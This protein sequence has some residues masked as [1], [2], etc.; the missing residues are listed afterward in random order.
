MTRLL[1]GQM[2]EIE[3]GTGEQKRRWHIHRELLIYQSELLEEEIGGKKNGDKIHLPDQ[4][5][6][7]FELFLKWLY[8]GKLDDVSDIPGQDR[9]YEYAVSCHKLYLLCERLGLEQ[10]KNIAMDQYRKGLNLSELVPDPNEIND[11]YRQSPPGS[12]WRKLMIQ[13][14]ARQIM[15]PQSDRDVST[16]RECFEGNPDFAIELVKSIKEATGGVLLDD[17]TEG[18]NDCD[19]HDHQTE[20]NCHMREHRGLKQG[21]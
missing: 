20:P 1:S 17:P 8:Q 15:D 6:A 14:A 9:Q 16:Y 5:P 10:L 21:K 18:D 3:V 7:G 2:I 11:I 19:Y 4:D 12:P 13:I